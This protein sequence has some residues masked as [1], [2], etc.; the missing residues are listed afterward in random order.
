VALRADGSVVTWGYYYSVGLGTSAPANLANVI[1]I[2]S[3]GDHDLGLFG[4]RAPS[5][6]VQPWD[7]TILNTTTSNTVFVGKCAGVQPISYQW[8]LNGTNLPTAT[9]DTLVLKQTGAGAPIPFVSGVYQLIASN[10]YGVVISRPAKL[11]AIVPLAT[12]L[13][14]ANLVWTTSGNSP[15]YG[16]TNTTHDG[17]DAARSGAIGATQE[18]ILQTTFGTNTSGRYTFWWKVSSEMDFDVLEF[19]VNGLTQTNISGEVNWQQVNIPVSAGTNVLQWRYSKDSSFDVGQDAGWVDQFAFYPDAPVITGQPVSL[20][21]NQ[22]TNLT[23]S[24]TATGAAPLR[25]Q[26]RQNGSIVSSSATL[27]LNNVSRAQ[28]GTYFVTVTNAG[29]STVSSNVTVK[30]LVPQVLGTPKLLPDGT[31]QLTSGDAGGGP[32]TTA[33]L[34]NF[35]V[36]VSTNLVNWATLPDGL[37]LTNGTLQLQDSGRTNS[38]SRFYR[39]IEH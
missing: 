8:Q 15:W 9:N 36:Q 20:I 5:F 23:L 34:A 1:R 4:T 38:P 30:V 3:G 6:T 28:S 22:G 26:W 21:V 24:V 19:R 29:G 7:R 32:I 18:T 11:T 25:Y 17:V 14:T 27:A 2:A 10:A 39:I 35:E 13:D 12:A 37:S 31:L 33:D 16:Q